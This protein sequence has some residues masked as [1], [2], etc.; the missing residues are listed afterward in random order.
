ML[1]VDTVVL[2]GEKIHRHARWPR[3]SAFA[4]NGTDPGRLLQRS[5]APRPAHS[6]MTMAGSRFPGSRVTASDHLPRISAIPVALNGRRLAAYSCGG[7]CGFVSCFAQKT[8]RIPLISPCGHYRARTWHSSFARVNAPSL[9]ARVD[10]ATVARK[11]GSQLKSSSAS[12]TRK[13]RQSVAHTSPL[14]PVIPVT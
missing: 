3:K 10:G 9:A 4:P 12:A 6:R 7:S 5:G 1:K 8:H 11:I 2:N 13:A 14:T